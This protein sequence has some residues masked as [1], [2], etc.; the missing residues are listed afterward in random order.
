M[1]IAVVESSA[2]AK[3]VSRDFGDGYRAVA[4]TRETGAAGGPRDP[5]SFQ[6]VRA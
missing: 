6:R 1:E 2:G 5:V 4:T 3:T